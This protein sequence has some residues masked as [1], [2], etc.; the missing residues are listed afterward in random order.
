MF[1]TDKV[2]VIII[3]KTRKIKSLFSNK[4]KVKHYSCVIYCGICSCGADYI[5]ETIRNS[6]IR[7]NKHITGKDQNSDCVKPLNNNFDHEFRWFVLSG[8]SK[9]RLKREILEAYCIKTC[10]PSLNNQ[11]NSDLLNLFRN[12][13]T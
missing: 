13:V 3:W 7:W 1:T 5:G 12:G 10:Q 9:N 8:P 2:K 6:E 4:D 11:I